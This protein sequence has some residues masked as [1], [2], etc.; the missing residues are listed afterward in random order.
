MGTTSANLNICRDRMYL[1]HTV[2][3]DARMANT[4]GSDSKNTVMKK[5]FKV[6]EFGL[7]GKIKKKL[8]D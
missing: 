6:L 7:L 5:F 3:S 1:R 2:L 4:I 8:V